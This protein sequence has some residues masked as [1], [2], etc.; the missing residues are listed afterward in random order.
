MN[1][2]GLRSAEY[3]GHQQRK[4]GR[5]ERC[6]AGRTGTSPPWMEA[7]EQGHF[8]HSAAQPANAHKREQGIRHLGLT[9]QG[10]DL[11]GTSDS[12]LQMTF[13]IGWRFIIPL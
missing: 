7:R 13:Q 2:Q 10:K 6:T 4:R 3:T 11:K 1:E 9:K 12:Y 5:W 8:L